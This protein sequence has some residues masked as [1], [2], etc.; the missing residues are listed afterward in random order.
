MHA[1]VIKESAY[2]DVCA[3]THAPR[4]QVD[5]VQGDWSKQLEQ[6]LKNLNKYKNTRA[7]S[8]L[9]F[10]TPLSSHSHPS[11]ILLSSIKKI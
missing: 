7:A 11:L 5:Q 4:M 10:V 9:I 2:R 8:I 3:P 6:T 1:G